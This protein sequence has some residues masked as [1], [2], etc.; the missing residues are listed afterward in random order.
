MFVGAIGTRQTDIDQMARRL[1]SKAPALIFAHEAGPTGYGLHRW[2]TGRGFECRVVEPSLIPKRP[3]DKVKTDR[4]DAVTLA[5]LLQ[6]GDRTGV[7]V[8]RIEDHASRDL[9]RARDAARNAWRRNY[10]R[11]RRRGGYSLSSRP[12]KHCAVCS[13][14]SRSRWS[15]SSAISPASIIRRLSVVGSLGGTWVLTFTDRDSC[16]PIIA[17]S[18]L[19]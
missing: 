9:S 13:G 4:R 16:V 8:P 1:E 7:Y 6:S 3:G 18:S 15:P 2:L 5:R 10:S 14:S 12:C 19:S 17:R 11:A